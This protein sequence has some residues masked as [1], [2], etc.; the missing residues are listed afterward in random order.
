[1][2]ALRHDAMDSVRY[3]FPERFAPPVVAWIAVQ[4]CDHMGRYYELRL[5]DGRVYLARAVD[6][7]QFAHRAAHREKWGDQTVIELDVNAWR[8]WGL[9][10]AGGWMGGIREAPRPGGCFGRGAVTEV[11]AGGYQIMR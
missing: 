11:C 9:S 7:G 1:M 3:W 4:N 2:V 6:C 5:P 8:R 10:L